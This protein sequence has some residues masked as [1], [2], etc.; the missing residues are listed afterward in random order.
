MGS[1][2]SSGMVSGPLAP[3]APGY[4][5]WLVDR[6]FRPGTVADRLSQLPHL[7]RWLEAEG[8]SVDE[9]DSTRLDESGWAGRA[10]GCVTWASSPSLRLPLAYLC[11]AGVVPAAGTRIVASPVARL[12]EGYRRYLI[13]ERG[14][15]MTTVDGYVCIARVFLEDRERRRDQL[16]LELLS[17]AD[18]SAYLALECQRQSIGGARGL[19]AK[20]RPLLVYL[21]VKG[22]IS[23]PLRW[24]LPGVADLQG[25]SLPRALEPTAVASLLASCDRRRTVGR[26]D[27]AILLLLVRLGLR[28]SEVAAMRL[29]D[30]DWR[31]GAI[32]V[33][34]KG[35]RQDRLP[36]PVDVGEALVAYLRVCPRTESRAVFIRAMAPVGPLSRRGVSGLVARAC[37]RAGVPSAGLT[38]SVTPPRRGCSGRAPPCRRSRRCSATSNSGRPPSTPKSTMRRSE[39]WRCRGRKVVQHELAERQA[40]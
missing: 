33:R 19:V 24:A 35:G 6:G 21:H 37:A 17:A 16:E 7:S 1:R 27:Y 12:L 26:R 8:L 34:G 13:L 10:A 28:S 20:L 40:G 4:E 5:Q 15:A 23:T 2:M 18:V 29:D 30:V 32:L 25:R 3:F 38:G 36:L 9:W 31:A 22:L 11:D 14:L 39:R